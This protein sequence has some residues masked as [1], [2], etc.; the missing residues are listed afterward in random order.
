MTIIEKF[1]QNF[2]FVSQHRASTFRLCSSVS[3][4]CKL[5]KIC[6]P[7]KVSLQK[8]QLR[9]CNLV[10]GNGNRFL[11][12][13]LKGARDN[14]KVGSP[15]SHQ[16]VRVTSQEF[17]SFQKVEDK[18]VNLPFTFDHCNAVSFSFICILSWKLIDVSKNST[19]LRHMSLRRFSTVKSH[20]RGEDGQ[21]CYLISP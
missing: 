17:I 15:T 14:S 18:A 13:R 6:R 10:L 3:A 5:Q 9:K 16:F 4:C 1:N 7:V 21:F 8:L 20:Y 12:V 19:N 11:M 2:S